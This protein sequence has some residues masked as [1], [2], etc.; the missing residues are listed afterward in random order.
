MRKN[1]ITMRSTPTSEHA[2]FLELSQTNYNAQSWLQ[3]WS[4]GGLTLAM[5]PRTSGASPRMRSMV[6][7]KSIAGLN[8]RGIKRIEPDTLRAL[9][10]L[11]VITEKDKY[12]VRV[13]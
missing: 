5:P 13:N 8:R 2:R 4:A 6:F 3:N 1:G 10:I 9:L 7:P 12:V 11:G